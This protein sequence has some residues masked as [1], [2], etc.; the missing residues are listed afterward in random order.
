MNIIE[1]RFKAND[2]VCIV[3][4]CYKSRVYAAYDA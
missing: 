3:P 4:R 2:L 1:Y